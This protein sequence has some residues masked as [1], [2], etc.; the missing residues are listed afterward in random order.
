MRCQNILQFRNLLHERA[1]RERNIAR[2]SGNVALYSKMFKGRLNN[3]RVKKWQRIIARA[4]LS[5]SLKWL[6]F[7]NDISSNWI[8][9]KIEILQAWN[10]YICKNVQKRNFQDPNVLQL[11]LR[12][13]RTLLLLSE[14]IIILEV[15]NGAAN[16]YNLNV[17]FFYIYISVEA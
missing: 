10:R 7:F 4:F 8:S 12:R 9:N 14:I 3:Q 16:E 11:L 1:D 13:S 5:M 15:K 17:F 6:Q 2:C